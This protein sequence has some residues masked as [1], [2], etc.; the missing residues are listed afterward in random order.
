M[1][2]HDFFQELTTKLASYE[3]P[4][5]RFS[6]F[7]IDCP[8]SAEIGELFN[9]WKNLK[10]LHLGDLHEEEGG[11]FFRD[12]GRPHFEDYDIVSELPPKSWGCPGLTE[13]TDGIHLRTSGVFAGTIS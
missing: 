6:V 12:D 1:T 2:P 10:F 7:S 8:F 4:I 5:E 13:Y 9:E 3:L 11:G